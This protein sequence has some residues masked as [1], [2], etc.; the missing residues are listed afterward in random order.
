VFEV[1][2]PLTAAALAAPPTADE[3]PEVAPRPIVEAEVP[4]AA[5]LPAVP[6]VVFPPRETFEPTVAALGALCAMALEAAIMEAAAR[7]THVKHLM[8][9]LLAILIDSTLAR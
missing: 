6:P 3:V 4:P 1:A 5:A 9:I 2:L 7:R 8:T